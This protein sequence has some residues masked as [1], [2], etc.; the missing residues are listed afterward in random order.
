MVGQENPVLPVW[1][2]Q[3]H[4]D[5]LKA[6][7]KR[8]LPENKS[9]D[10]LSLVS[11]NFL[12]FESKCYGVEGCSNKS[13]DQKCTLFKTKWRYQEAGTET[14]NDRSI[15][16]KIVELYNDYRAIKKKKSQKSKGA[17]EARN[18]FEASLDTLFNVMRPD[19][20]DLIRADSSRSRQR[21]E[22]DLAFL[23]DQKTER[24]QG[25]SSIDQK[26]VKIMQNKEKREAREAA[27]VLKEKN[28][29]EKESE[30]NFV[31]TSVDSS[32]AGVNT[33]NTDK[34]MESIKEQITSSTSRKRRR[35]RSGEA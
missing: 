5:I 15:A 25:M 27:Q 24:K 12:Q 20:E 9:L 29:V 3:T 17:V 23:Q 7:H 35:T 13:D 19:A 4:R 21:K 34:S 2:L 6:V 16:K 28:R 26:H 1:V 22:E 30:F 10:Q 8:S 18:S 33:T 14:I 32:G 11:C 31:D